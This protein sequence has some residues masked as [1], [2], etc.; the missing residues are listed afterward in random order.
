MTSESWEETIAS[1]HH[2]ILCLF[3]L[4]ILLARKHSGANRCYFS[5]LFD[6]TRDLSL[7]KGQ[8]QFTF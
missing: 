1:L 7:E 8:Q 2:S 3:S 4:D 6:D 5:L